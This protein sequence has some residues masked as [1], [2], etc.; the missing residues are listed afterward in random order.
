MVQIQARVRQSANNNTWAKSKTQQTRN[1]VNNQ[2]NMI[3]N[4]KGLALLGKGCL[5]GVFIYVFGCNWEQV[6]SNKGPVTV[7][8]MHG[9]STW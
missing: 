2:K 8:V 6:C 5:A 1:R 9:C 7:N 4:T 3:I